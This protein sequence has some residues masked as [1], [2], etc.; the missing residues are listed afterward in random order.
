MTGGS[1]DTVWCKTI[2]TN[3]DLCPLWY[4]TAGLNGDGYPRFDNIRDK[5]VLDMIDELKKKGK[6]PF[7]DRIAQEV[8]GAK[9]VPTY[10][11]LEEAIACGSKKIR[12]NIAEAIQ[13]K[14]WSKD[15]IKHITMLGERV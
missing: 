15:D 10:F 11:T 7:E 1:Y 9:R 8:Y 12:E 14:G 3:D 6:S 5:D 4:G 2:Y 13:M